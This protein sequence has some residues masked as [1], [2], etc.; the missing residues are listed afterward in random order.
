MYY[1]KYLW[2]Y[3]VFKYIIIMFSKVMHYNVNSENTTFRR[4]NVLLH[5]K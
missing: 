3:S 5:V 1:Q 2:V 4:I